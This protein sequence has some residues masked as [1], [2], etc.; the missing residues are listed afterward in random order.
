MKKIFLFLL[1]SIFLIALGSAWSYSESYTNGDATS[2]IS[3]S[4]TY[5]I[6][7]GEKDGSICYGRYYTDISYSGNGMDVAVIK[8]RA[9]EWIVA[10]ENGFSSGESTFQEGRHYLDDNGK[11]PKFIICG[12]NYKI[13]SNGD[14]AWVSQCGGYLG[15]GYFD[16]LKVVEC[17]K[18]S[19][20]ASDEFCDTRSEFT[21]WECR[22][23]SICEDGETKC[24]GLKLQKCISYGDYSDWFTYS[25]L[26][27]GECG[28]DCL[29]NSDCLELEDVL[30]CQG[31]FLMKEVNTNQCVS[32]K[33]QETSR[34]EIEQTCFS[35]QKCE[36]GE[37]VLTEPPK[38]EL[39]G[40]AQFFA[41]IWDWIKSLFEN[42]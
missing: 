38:P 42:K 34:N 6:C 9:S 29:S 22:R 35:P 36:N 26:E 23:Q 28:V 37:C 21:E 4:G 32:N 12:W 30:F 40:F 18:D 3:V 31:N 25:D 33:C 7:D 14:W 2:T 1:I 17:F 16:E 20:C 39:S 41:N 19:H 24:D 8:E 5:P 11:V 10:T 15:T 13:A 27:I